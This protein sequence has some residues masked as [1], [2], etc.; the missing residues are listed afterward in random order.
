MLTNA[1]MRIPVGK[2]VGITGV[3][4][5]GKTTAADILLGLLNP[6]AGRILADGIDISSYYREWLSCVGYI[7]QMIFMLDDTI[8][9]NIAFGVP[10][11]EVDDNKVWEALEEAQLADFVRSLPE[12]LDTEIGERG[13]RLSG[14]QRQRTGVARALYTNPALLIFDEATS[15]LDHGTEAALMEAIGHLRGKKTMIIIAHRLQTIEMC[16]M[17]YRVEDGGFG[18]KGNDTIPCNILHIFS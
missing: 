10:A 14:G 17:V 12:K 9:S 15:A 2:S 13:I 16:D 4:G 8:R 1:E 7:P 3:S 18:G 11:E 6:Q 5:A